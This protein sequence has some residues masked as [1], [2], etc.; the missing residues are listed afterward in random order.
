MNGAYAIPC[1]NNAIHAGCH[2][3]SCHGGKQ[4]WKEPGEHN[5]TPG[6]TIPISG[7]PG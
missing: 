4:R 3:A 1:A 7:K 6:L 5:E 2:H